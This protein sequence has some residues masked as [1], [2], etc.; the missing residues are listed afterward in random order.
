MHNQVKQVVKRTQRDYS[1]GCKIAVVSEVERGLLG[2]KEAQRKYGIQGRSTVLVW[3]RKHGS[4]DWSPQTTQLMSKQQTPAQEIKRLKRKLHHLI[5]SELKERGIKLGRDALFSHLRDEQMLI[6]P[7][8]RYTKTTYTYSWMRKH[9]NLFNGL[10]IKRPE[11]AFVSDIT[12]IESGEGVHYLSLVTDACSRKVMGHELS[13]Q[14]KASDTAKALHRAVANR[15]S[16]SALM[17]YS[18]KSS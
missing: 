7:K 10:E 16:Q 5:Q 14:M 12:Y 6:R 18:N 9:P 11:Q 4:L 1:L 3:L 2:Y 17:A 8:R 15:I 13:W